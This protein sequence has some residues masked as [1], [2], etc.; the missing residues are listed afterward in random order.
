[1]SLEHSALQAALLHVSTL[2]TSEIKI[3]DV[4]GIL[5][6]LVCFKFALTLVK[7]DFEHMISL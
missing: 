4:K 3:E 6:E 2:P 7:H 1:M 5:K